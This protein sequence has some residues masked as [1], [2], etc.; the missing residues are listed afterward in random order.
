MGLAGV[1]SMSFVR[2]NK[3]PALNSAG[4]LFLFPWL[5]ANGVAQRASCQASR[6]R[7]RRSS[8]RPV[9]SRIIFFPWTKYFIDRVIAA[10]S[11]S[12]SA[13][14]WI[15][16]VS[17]GRTKLPWVSDARKAGRWRAG[18]HQLGQFEFLNRAWFGGSNAIPSGETGNGAAWRKIIVDGVAS[19]ASVAARP[20]ARANEPRSAK[21]GW[22]MLPD[23]GFV[24]ERQAPTPPARVRCQ[25]SFRQAITSALPI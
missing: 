11:L 7:M 22:R 4:N 15:P 13:S 20:S 17:K 5:K 9:R 10:P 18:R 23:W 25:N 12:S 2:G 6:R 24:R 1:V 21:I 3:N 8:S 14:K 19:T 16:R